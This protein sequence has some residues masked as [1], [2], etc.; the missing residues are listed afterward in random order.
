L[1]YKTTGVIPGF[2]RDP[3]DDRLDATTIMYK[4]L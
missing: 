3:F 2:C 4:A 1:G